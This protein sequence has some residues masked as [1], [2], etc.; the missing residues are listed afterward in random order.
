LYLVI[1]P[2]L[3]LDQ[4]LV[5]LQKINEEQSM[6]A[7]WKVEAISNPMQVDSIA[8]EEPSLGS[9]A[10]SAAFEKMLPHLNIYLPA[11]TPP[12]LREVL[13]D[14]DETLRLDLRAV[15][16]LQ[17]I[18]GRSD[19][20]VW[21]IPPS[22]RAAYIYKDHL[23]IDLDEQCAS[24]FRSG[25]LK[26]LQ[27]LYS[28]VNSLLQSL[29]QEKVFILFGGRLLEENMGYDFSSALHFNPALVREITP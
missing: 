10:K 6:E 14:G 11:S 20:G 1:A 3:N 22:L 12:F 4:V 26:S 9:T 13:V 16:I 24:L 17:E 19:R 28:L 25:D 15:R 8:T 7:G 27:L 29:K 21:T 23:M 5:Q 2:S 18:T